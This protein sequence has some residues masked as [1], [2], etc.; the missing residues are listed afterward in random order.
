[1]LENHD[2]KV[3]A[4]GD[5]GAALEAATEDPDCFD[6]LVTDVVMPTTSGPALAEKISTLR[7]DLPVLFMSGYE[8]GAL[9]AGAPVLSRNHLAPANLQRQS[10]LCSGGEAESP[11][12]GP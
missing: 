1:M 7:P 8:A 4:F 12:R 10:A 3:R 11:R 6:A 9:L 5:P 2:Y